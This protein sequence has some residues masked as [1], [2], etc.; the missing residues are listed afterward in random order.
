MPVGQTRFHKLRRRGDVR[1]MLT[2]NRKSS[3]VKQTIA[4]EA[5]SGPF[6]PIPRRGEC[7]TGERRN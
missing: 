2:A 6:G 1:D 5:I 7:K 4:F 3:G